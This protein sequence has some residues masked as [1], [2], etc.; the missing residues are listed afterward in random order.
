MKKIFTFLAGIFV[1]ALLTNGA[2][3]SSRKAKTTVPSKPPAT[4][5]VKSPSTAVANTSAAAVAK[6]AFLSVA[7]TMKEIAD[8]KTLLKA[9]PLSSGAPRLAVILAALDPATSQINLLSVAKDS[10]LTKG[11]DLLATTQLGNQVQLHV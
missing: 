10:F 3:A 6:T 2:A 5:P 7:Q 4:A 9:R 8:S 1:C 11:A